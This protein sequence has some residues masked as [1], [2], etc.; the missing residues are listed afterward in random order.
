MKDLVFVSFGKRNL[1]VQSLTI[2]EIFE[3][4]I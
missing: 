2:Q 4:D 3:L 1:P